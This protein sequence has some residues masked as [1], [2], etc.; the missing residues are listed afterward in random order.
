MNINTLLLDF[1]SLSSIL[2]GI[3]VITSRNPVI[4]VLFLIAV[5]VNAAGYLLLSGIHFI[6]ITYI[7]IYVGAIAILFL[8][9]VMMMNI[10]LVELTSVGQEYTKNLPLGTIIGALFF[11]ELLTIFPIQVDINQINLLNLNIFY[12]LN[13]LFNKLNLI[14]LDSYN[15]PESLY[16]LNK[17]IDLTLNFNNL[18]WDNKI[19][20]FQQIEAIGHS[21]YTNYAI[22]FFLASAILLLAMI[23]PI[24]LCLKS[25][26]TSIDSDSDYKSIH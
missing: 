1:L 10:K 24:I 9:V 12:Y 8:F 18:I 5:F 22:W 2:S 14:Q 13:I 25:A 7:I 15:K 11:Y 21:F 6:G 19:V 17:D 20:S 3:F 23:G 4:S 26:S 16:Y